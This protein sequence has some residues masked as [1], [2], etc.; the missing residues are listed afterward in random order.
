MIHNRCLPLWLHRVCNGVLGVAVLLGLGSVW[1]GEPEDT[2]RH[3][4]SRCLIWFSIP[5]GVILALTARRLSIVQGVAG[6]EGYD[7]LDS[8]GA[9]KQSEEREGASPDKPDP[10]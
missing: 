8:P 10:E 2:W 9:A 1:Y 4:V 7:E 5:A 6:R 3:F